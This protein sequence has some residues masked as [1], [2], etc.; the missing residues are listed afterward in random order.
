VE[1][2]TSLISNSKERIVSV[3]R[4][5]DF[6]LGN[7]QDVLDLIATVHYEYDSS[8]MIMKKEDI[9]P[10]FFQLKTRLLGGI[11]QKFVNYKA[12]LA[13]VGDFSTCESKSFRDFMYESN[14]GN[15]L[16]F[17]STEAEAIA[18]LSK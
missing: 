1:Y 12:S 9:E 17:A 11:M 16:F 8:K 14:H 7:E 3:S 6:L 5:G 4:D 15:T 18:F 10:H 2:I 13:I